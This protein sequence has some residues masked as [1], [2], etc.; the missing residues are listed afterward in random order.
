MQIQHLKMCFKVSVFQVFSV[1]T[2]LL[3]K[4]IKFKNRRDN[5]MFEGDS[6]ALCE[7]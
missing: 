6:G 5:H 3:W 4:Q 7:A 2:Q 1:L